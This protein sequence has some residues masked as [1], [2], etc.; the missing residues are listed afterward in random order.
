MSERVTQTVEQ[1]GA[2]TTITVTPDLAWLQAP[3]RQ[4]PVV[5]DPTVKI[6]PTIPDAQDTQI[7]ST[8]PTTNYGTT[9]PLSV[10]T[11]ST[12]A[13]R[14]LVRF[15]LTGIPAGTPIDSAQLRM[16]YDQTHTTFANDVPIE[17][18]RI[19]A[20]WTETTATWSTIASSIGGVPSNLEQVDDGDAGKTAST[21]AWPY[22]T[23]TALTPFALNGDYAANKDTVVGD[24]YTWV[25][26][27]TEAGTY[28]V[29]AHYVPATDRATAAPYTVTFS[30]GSTVKNVNQAAGTGGVWAPLGSWNFAAGTTGKVVLKD[31]TDT[32]KAT[33][34][35]AVRFTKP[36]VEHQEGG[37]LQRVALLQRPQHRAELG[38]RHPA[39]LRADAQGRRRGDAGAGRAD[40]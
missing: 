29:D 22:S 40:V 11:T 9:W 6:E 16:Y 38:R 1:H 19:S 20:P 37:D 12:G 33:V 39:E 34:A 10:G 15:P 2:E 3:E 18:R 25:P 14:S 31:S 36:A 26:R 5:V 13:Y 4:Y 8:A 17:A 7:L 21:E 24:T 28:D 27:I 32:T 35:D 23:N 30:G